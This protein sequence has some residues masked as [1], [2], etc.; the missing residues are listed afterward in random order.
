MTESSRIT[1]NLQNDDSNP[2]V[3]VAVPVY[4]HAPFVRKCLESIFAVDYRPLEVIIINDQSPDNSD[5]VIR[6]FIKSYSATNITIQYIY[7]EQNLGLP[8]SL[9]EAIQHSHGAYFCHISGDDTM[10]SKGIME[11]VNYLQAHPSKLSVFSDCHVVDD[12]GD[13]VC[14]S[15]IEDLHPRIGMRKKYLTVDRLILY[16]VVFNFTVAGAAFMCRNLLF[17]QIGIYDEELLIEDWDLYIR[18]ASVGLLGFCNTYVANFRLHDKNMHKLFFSQPV[19][20]ETIKRIVDKHI[21]LTNGLIRLRFISRK[22]LI[23]ADSH[24]GKMGRSVLKVPA[25]GLSAGTKIANSAW[26]AG[27][28]VGHVVSRW[29]QKD[30]RGKGSLG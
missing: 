15:V 5:E 1:N 8:K 7:H 9:N 24:Q 14:D 27:V 10:L 6:D 4:N 28:Y 18:A 11:R 17:D 21:P 29:C 2:L 30:N 23:I 22:L 12:Q 13:R 20:R 16:S 19:Y 25:K 3:T 26:C